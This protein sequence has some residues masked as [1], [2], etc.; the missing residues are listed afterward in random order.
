[1]Q[2]NLRKL[3]ESLVE[4]NKQLKDMVYNLTFYANVIHNM[5]KNSQ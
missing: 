5:H 1:M 3:L 4:R 2:C